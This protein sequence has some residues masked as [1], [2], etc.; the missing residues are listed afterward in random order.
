MPFVVR[1]RRLAETASRSSERS[2][3][4]PH[5]AATTTRQE[6]ALTRC[7]AGSSLFAKIRG[8][9][10]TSVAELVHDH[11]WVPHRINAPVTQIEFVRLERTQH[12]ALTFL[13][14]RF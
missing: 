5:P 6:R 14:E 10:M 7:A 3:T 9:G 11:C 2:V 4:R 1:E 8:G 12:R 13:E